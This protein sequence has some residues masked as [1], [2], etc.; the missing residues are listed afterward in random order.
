MAASS[1]SDSFDQT[2]GRFP[3]GDSNFSASMEA[4]GT[5]VGFSS[6]VGSSSELFGPGQA[7]LM[8]QFNSNPRAGAASMMYPGATSM[9]PE[10]GN[11]A[12]T[13]GGISTGSAF[14]A[15]PPAS[16]TGDA[17]AAPREC[18]DSTQAAYPQLGANNG[19]LA[20]AFGFMAGSSL[21]ATSAD[22]S[23]GPDPHT[24]TGC[25]FLTPVPGAGLRPD[26]TSGPGQHAAIHGGSSHGSAGNGSAPGFAFVCANEGGRGRGAGRG[27]GLG[28]GRGTGGVGVQ[29]AAGANNQ[30]E[31][32]AAQG[33]LGGAAPGGRG[34]PPQGVQSDS[35]DSEL[36]AE[37]Q[38]DPEPEAFQD[39][40]AEASKFL[41]SMPTLDTADNLHRDSQELLE[42]QEHQDLEADLE[43][44]VEVDYPAREEE[45]DF[46]EL[47][48]E[49][50]FLD[51]EAEDS[52][53]LA[54]EVTLD[55]E[56]EDH[57]HSLVEEVS[58]HQVV[59]VLVHPA[60][61]HLEGLGL[62]MVPEL[63][64]LAQVVLELEHLLE[65]GTT[66]LF[67]KY[68]TALLSGS[69]NTLQIPV[70]CLHPVI[71]ISLCLILDD[72][73]RAAAFAALGIPVVTE[74]LYQE[75]MWSYLHEACLYYDLERSKPI[76]AHAAKNKGAPEFATMAWK[77][78]CKE[79]DPKD[80][81]SK[82]KK[83]KK[84][85]EQIFS[86]IC[87]WKGLFYKV[88]HLHTMYINLGG[89]FGAE[90][91]LKKI[92]KAI[93]CWA[94]KPENYLLVLAQHWEDFVCNEIP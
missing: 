77:G 6:H 36:Q 5:N 54:V 17:L 71:I 60:V 25:R 90:K 4:L 7:S 49:A 33:G 91:L 46:L 47:E 41:V 78:I 94:L 16:S 89:E 53:D 85:K 27:A 59:E 65:A 66:T 55:L 70:Y 72:T 31:S 84:L 37:L 79:F 76:I 35:Q 86:F 23:H 30:Q 12:S 34:A 39:L 28:A 52:L 82:L 11:L 45:A 21:N 74:Y 20:L 26:S 9:L 43:P 10:L 44:V 75:A 8:Q 18:R 51:L 80:A 83:K 61:V 68:L 3:C 93:Y 29:S 24:G 64:Y 73:A 14:A 19:D 67:P 87:Y 56:E 63:E 50:D 22:A 2:N 42:D 48:E 15:F 13:L 69:W 38:Q 81:F 62:V 88:M 32:G 92:K 57:Q 1:T 40:A 58:H